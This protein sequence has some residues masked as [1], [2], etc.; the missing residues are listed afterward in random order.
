ML[1]ASWAHAVA[2]SQQIRP[3]SSCTSWFTGDIAVT[4]PVTLLTCD[5][6]TS[7]IGLTISRKKKEST[8]T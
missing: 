8:E 3:P 5:S 2:Q 1:G 6:D 4:R 7:R